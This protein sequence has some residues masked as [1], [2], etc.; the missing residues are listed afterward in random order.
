MFKRQSSIADA[1]FSPMG[2]LLA[3]A[4]CYDWSKGAEGNDMKGSQVYVHNLT[5]A[6]VTPKKK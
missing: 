2:N 3:Y 5:P 1:K 6:E 4:V